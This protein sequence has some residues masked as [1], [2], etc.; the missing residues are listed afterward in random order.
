MPKQLAHTQH[1]Q[2]YLISTDPFVFTSYHK[3][4]TPY[5]PLV[6][7]IEGD[8]RSVT[9]TQQVSANPTP[10][11]PMALKLAVLHSPTANIAYLAR[12]CQ[13]TSFNTDQAC[14]PTVW[15]HTRF[16]EKV[17]QSMNQAINKLKE[18]AKATEIHLIGFSGR[19][20]HC[21]F[22]CRKKT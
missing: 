13:Y 17:I 19:R 10:C 9:A 12:P 4:K 5:Q 8:G 6:V 1:F 20:W 3:F 15:S 21:G 14:H 2:K 16:S 22:N 7:Y 11:N 18:K